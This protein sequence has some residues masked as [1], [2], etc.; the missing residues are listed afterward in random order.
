[1]KNQSEILKFTFEY[2]KFYIGTCQPQC[3]PGFLKLPLRNCNLFRLIFQLILQFT[4]I[5]KNLK[6]KKEVGIDYM[7]KK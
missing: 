1:M 4:K 3:V 6:F 5:I 7:Y 2:I